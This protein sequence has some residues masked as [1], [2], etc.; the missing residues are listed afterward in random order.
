M[1][2]MIDETL[3][4]ISELEATGFLKGRRYWKKCR[5]DGQNFSRFDENYKLTDP[6]STTPKH[7]LQNK[8]HIKAHHNQ[9]MKGNIKGNQRGEKNPMHAMYK[10]AKI[11]TRTDI[12]GK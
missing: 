5:N 8:N 7:M 6:K 9:M 4:K 10:G 11:M 1:E 12:S 3:Q 2:L